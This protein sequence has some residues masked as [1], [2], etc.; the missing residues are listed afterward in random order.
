MTSQQ[1]QVKPLRN[2]EIKLKVKNVKG[3][4]TDWFEK[5][6]K[7]VGAFLYREIFMTNNNCKFIMTTSEQ[8]ANLLLKSNYSLI[9]VSGGQ[10]TFLN[11]G[12]GL[13]FEKL[14]S[15]VYTDKIFI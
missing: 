4:S 5:I 1:M 6:I 15:A 13:L 10:W 14:D 11:N 12:K 3:V 8:T 2:K 9:N 7:S